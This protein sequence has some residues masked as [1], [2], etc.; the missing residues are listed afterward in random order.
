MAAIE[1]GGCSSAGVS[2]QANA[3]SNSKIVAEYDAALSMIADGK[4]KAALEKLS[5]LFAEFERSDDE[6]HASESIFWIGYC[7]EKL[8]NYKQAAVEYRKV[9]LRYPQSSAAG[10]AKERLARL[11]D[12]G[13]SPAA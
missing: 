5:P 9:M 13:A 1:I 7:Q 12:Q 6:V 11:P 8:S 10:Q 3:W 2:F 4:Y